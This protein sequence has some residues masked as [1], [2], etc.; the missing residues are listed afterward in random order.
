MFKRFVRLHR[1]KSNWEFNLLDKPAALFVL[2]EAPKKPDVPSFQNELKA[3]YP[4]FEDFQ[5]LFQYLTWNHKQDLVATDG[6][7]NRF[8]LILDVRDGDAQSE[9]YDWKIIN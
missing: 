6:S 9:V 3:R 7:G 5:E 8:Q 1:Y 2:D 4:G